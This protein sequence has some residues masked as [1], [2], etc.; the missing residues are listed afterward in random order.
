MHSHTYPAVSHVFNIHPNLQQL[1]LK[2]DA[3][4]KVAELFTILQNNNTLKYLE[5]TVI[6]ESF[7][8]QHV[9]ISLQNMLSSNKTLKSF[10]IDFYDI[11]SVWSLYSGHLP[12]LVAGLS[13]NNNLKTLRVPISF[14]SEKADHEVRKSFFGI[15]AKKVKLVNLDLDL[16]CPWYDAEVAIHE[17][18]EN[19]LPVITRMLETHK[20]LIQ[21]KLYLRADDYGQTVKSTKSAEKFWQAV[22]CHP[23]LQ[24]VSAS[25]S[26][27]KGA[28]EVA[29]KA[30]KKK[31]CDKQLLCSYLPITEAK[32]RHK[33][34]YSYL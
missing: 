14:F 27:H 25:S 3:P 26:T 12:Y 13:F 20:T 23:T 11:G 31:I 29:L 7:Y 28:F 22:F 17:F 30:E 21:F 33:F 15:I 5:M 16:W 1:N 34:S 2:L 18:F 6:C 8:D 19:D 10:E 4:K 9:L 24:Y 32:H